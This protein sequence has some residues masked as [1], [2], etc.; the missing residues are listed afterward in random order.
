ML[1]ERGTR[2]ERTI[3]VEVRT[4]EFFDG[5]GEVIAS[6]AGCWPRLQHHR[7]PGDAAGE[8]TRSESE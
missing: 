6:R 8:R 5:A 1:L 4:E 3:H 2:S 7:Q